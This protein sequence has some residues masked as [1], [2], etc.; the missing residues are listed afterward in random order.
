MRIRKTL[1]AFDVDNTIN[2]KF[3]ESAVFEK[4]N[5]IVRDKYIEGRKSWE[6]RIMTAT[7]KHPYTLQEVTDHIKNIGIVPGMKETF[8]NLKSK[9][10]DIIICSGGND[11]MIKIYLEQQGLN[12]HVSA[13]LSNRMK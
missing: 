12:K 4:I 8:D 7:S 5:P 13:I 9:G 10:V 2:T 1:A 6:E 11:L 3:L